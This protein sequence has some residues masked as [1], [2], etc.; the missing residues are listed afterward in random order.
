[1]LCKIAIDGS[2]YKVRVHCNQVVL[3]ISIGYVAES[4]FAICTARN[5]ASGHVLRTH[6]PNIR[7]GSFESRDAYFLL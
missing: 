4:D 1:M 3:L 6:F 7:M 2:Q 5:M